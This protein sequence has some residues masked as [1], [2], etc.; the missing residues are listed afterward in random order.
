[1]SNNELIKQLK[2]GRSTF[3]KLLGEGLRE[4]FIRKNNSGYV[5]DNQLIMND[6]SK[7][8]SEMK[9]ELIDYQSVTIKSFYFSY[10][11]KADNPK[12]FERWCLGGCPRKK[13][14]ISDKSLTSII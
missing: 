2:I 3:F 14:L 7:S 6:C 10:I 12:A 9:M 1:M 11:D 5:I 4:G 8:I 13:R